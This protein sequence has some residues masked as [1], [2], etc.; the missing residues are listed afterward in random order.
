MRLIALERATLLAAAL[1]LLAVCV[2]AGAQT[3]TAKQQQKR[4]EIELCTT[5]TLTHITKVINVAVSLS[6]SL[7]LHMQHGGGFQ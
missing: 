7:S 4:Y 6:P 5:H 2:A 1:P 3:H